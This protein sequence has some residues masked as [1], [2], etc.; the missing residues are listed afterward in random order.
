MKV[1]IKY[2]NPDIKKRKDFVKK[3]ISLLQEEYPLKADLKIMLHLMFL[4]QIKKLK[5]LKIS[6]IINLVLS[7]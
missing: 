4:I 6:I 1:S 3:F 7:L 2:E 5:V